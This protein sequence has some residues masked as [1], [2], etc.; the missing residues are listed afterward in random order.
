MTLRN[1]IPVD[2]AADRPRAGVRIVLDAGHGGS[3][4]G[5][6]GPLRAGSD[7][8]GSVFAASEKDLNLSVTLA[9]AEKLRALGATVILTRD[10]DET[11][12][13][14]ERARLLE[15]LE[16]DLCI[17]LHQNSIGYTSDITK[18]R[19]TL[20]LWCAA[21]GELLADCV[22]RCV[23]ASLCRNYRGTQWQALAMCRN[24]RF[25]SALIEVG[26][27]TS[28]EE[29]EYMLSE[30]GLEAAAQGVADGVLEYFRRMTF[31][32]ENQ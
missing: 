2:P 27:M 20:G 11:F 24:P 15:K 16:P 22:G 17:S 14:L 10:G 3:D 8:T 30:R 31:Y 29:Y 19:G 4:P 23:A 32:A 9:A 5:A 12:D 1:P 28:V 13:V 21:G 7:G 26:F 18:I 25:P 6:F